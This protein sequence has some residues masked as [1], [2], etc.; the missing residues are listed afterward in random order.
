MHDSMKAKISYAAKV[1]SP[2]NRTFTVTVDLINC[3]K[4]L[5]PNM[6]A[7][8]KII[9]YVNP[10]AIV[11]PVSAIQRAEE[12]DFVFI[13]Q[14]GKAKKIRVKVG[15]TYNGSAEII[16]GLNEGDKFISKGYQEL[17]DG[18]EIKF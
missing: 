17:N 10:K 4:D 12:G 7:I 14:N 8:L 5:H 3:M 11:V 16:S 6:I 18:E 15:K 1:I 9:D 2:L 13:A